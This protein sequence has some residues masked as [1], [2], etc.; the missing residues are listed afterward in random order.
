LNLLL[1]LRIA[2]RAIEKNKFRSS[3]TVLGVVIGVAAVTTMV[4]LG[5]SA[6]RLIQDQL[7]SLGTNV[8]LV[9]PEGREASRPRT[10]LTAADSDAILDACPSIRAATPLVGLTGQITYGHFHHRP[11]LAGVGVDYLTIRNWPLAYGEF[12][13]ERDINASGNVCVLGQTVIVKLF[14]TTNPFGKTV[15]IGKVPFR[16]I[17]VLQP[18]GAN[19]LGQDQDDIVLLP[20]STVR[21]RLQGVSFNN[22]DSILLSARS[23]EETDSAKQQ[24]LRLLNH[25][26]KIPPD[27]PTAFRI[28][29]MKEFVAILDI[30]M[31]TLTV[32]LA[33]IAAI[34]LLVGGIGIMNIMLVSVTERTREIGIRMAVGAHAKDIMRQFLVEAVVLSTMGGAVGVALGMGASVGTIRI[35]NAM[36]PDVNWPVVISLPAAAVAISFAIG[37]GIFFGYYPALRASRLDPIDALRYE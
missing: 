10:L 22:V 34:S 24:I 29:D 1:V 32:T 6:A 26:H 20:F 25:R 7:Y 35:V 37:V 33:A 21:Q 23:A 14:Q 16:V 9:V 4:S 27:Q 28:T 15:R 8:L 30:V 2:I 17:G 13:A 31:K 3:L 19:L 12:F 5:Q 11:V 18:K 36:T